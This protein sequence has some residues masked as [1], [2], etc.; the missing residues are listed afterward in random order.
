MYVDWMPAKD[1]ESGKIQS[2]SRAW[3]EI[4]VF[5]FVQWLKNLYLQLSI[6]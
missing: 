3:T 6:L 4:S 2:K 1:Q 5:I